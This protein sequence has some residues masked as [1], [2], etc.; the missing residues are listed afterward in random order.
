MNLV[1]GLRFSLRF[2]RVA[3]THAL[4]DDGVLGGDE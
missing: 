3:E 4:A 1:R 2:V